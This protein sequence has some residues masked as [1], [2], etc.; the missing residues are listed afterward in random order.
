MN[1]VGIKRKNRIENSETIK[2][3]VHWLYIE[4]RLLEDL[5]FL[6]EAVQFNAEHMNQAMQFK[7]QWIGG[8]VIIINIVWE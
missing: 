4:I 2:I 3:E 6:H 5:V 8:V 1:N 7:I